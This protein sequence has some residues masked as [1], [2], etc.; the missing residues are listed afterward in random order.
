MAGVVKGLPP[1]RSPGSA[2]QPKA[3]PP[4]EIQTGM[5]SWY[6]RPHHG[7]RMASGEV[8]N[9]HALTAAHPSLPLGTRV[10]VTHVK[11]GRSVEVRINDRG[12]IVRGRI[13]DLSYAAAQRLGAVDE[14]AFRVKLRTLSDHSPAAP[15]ANEKDRRNSALDEGR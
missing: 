12:P 2:P 13:I 3:P 14:G 6:G 10:L 11:N 8:F 15:P 7:R 5:A 1:E 9:M 4:G